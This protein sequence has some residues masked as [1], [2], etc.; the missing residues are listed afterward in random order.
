M[1]SVN[2]V[3]LMGNLGRDPEVRYS[4]SGSALC[5]MSI[6]TTRGSALRRRMSR[7]GHFG[8]KGQF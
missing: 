5:S 7:Y 3:F 1:P 4:P 6:A 8:N 2:K